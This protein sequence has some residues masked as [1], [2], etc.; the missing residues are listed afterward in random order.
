MRDSAVTARTTRFRTAIAA[1]LLATAVLGAGPAEADVVVPVSGP[2]TL[3]AFTLTEVGSTTPIRTM[4]PAWPRST[5]T[6][7]LSVPISY[8]GGVTGLGS[9]E[10]CWWLESAADCDSATPDPETTFV[11]T[12]GLTDNGDGTYAEAFTVTDGA[13]VAYSDESSSTNFTAG[14]YDID[15][16]FRFKVSS[17]MRHSSSWNLQIT[18]TDIAASPQ[19]SV[20]VGDDY[21]VAYFASINTGRAAQGWGP[22]LQGRS[23]TKDGLS[24]GTYT[25]NSES[26][27]TLAATDF[28]DGNGSVLPLVASASERELV[29]Q[30]SLTS[31][32]VQNHAL[33]VIGGNGASEIGRQNHDVTV[34]LTP[35]DA[36]TLPTHSCRL[37]YPQGRVTSPNTTHTN[38]VTI[39]IIAD[40][41]TAPANLA[42]TSTADAVD[43]SW[44]VPPVVGTMIGDTT[45]S[46]IDYVVEQS[47]DGGTSWAVYERI[48]S[49]F[50][51]SMSTSVT[52]LSPRS[53]YRFRVTANT[54]AGSGA[55]EIAVSTGSDATDTEALLQ[56]VNAAVSQYTEDTSVSTVVNALQG[57][58]PAGGLR[59]VASPTYGGVAES[60]GSQTGN[61]TNKGV[62]RLDAFQSNDDLALSAGFSDSGLNDMPYL[63]F[64]GFARGRF[65]GSGVMLYEDYSTRTDIELRD[66]FSPNQYRN[67]DA[68]VLNANGTYVRYNDGTGS[69]TTR[70]IFSDGHYPG[71]NGYYRTNRFA[72]DDGSW[73]FNYGSSLD[74]N[75]GPYHDST[76]SYGAA[77]QNS[78]DTSAQRFNWGNTTLSTT[79][80]VFYFFVVYEAP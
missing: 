55:S 58:N 43:L 10:M 15:I 7:N 44:D 37:S 23:A 31:S 70:T 49:G 38:T 4:T 46:V 41:V 6:Y 29:M 65:Y 52:N 9:V 59:V 30:C 3:G 1:A 40:D 8:P 61:L 18:A 2:P 11:M 57:V 50:A 79:D 22:I 39:G 56:S 68:Y 20:R 64:V 75:G 71:S 42:G 48:T 14:T 12:W 35:E 69:G 51:A 78:G 13:S 80:Y 17:A 16:D 45:V 60:M 77:N 47:G 67:L 62:F 72:S 73:G 5:T 28:S 36:Q 32:F 26:R 25:A 54:D 53:N 24:T 76:D 63:G 33:T 19:S 21:R 34:D 27:L 74:G 66:L